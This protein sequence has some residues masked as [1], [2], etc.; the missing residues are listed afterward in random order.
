MKLVLKPLFEAE[1]PG[2]FVEV[3]RQKLMGREIKEGEIVEIELLGKPLGFK[4]LYSEPKILKVKKDTRIELLSGEISIVELDLEE[5]AKDLLA[6]KDGF[7]VVFEDGVLILNHN[8]HKIYKQEFE[9]L[10]KVRITKN[11]VAV[12]HDE[13]LTLITLP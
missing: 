9:S 2:D 6:F 5:E 13:K 1:L 7:I 3:L 11:V 12:L 8:G 10:K 4:V